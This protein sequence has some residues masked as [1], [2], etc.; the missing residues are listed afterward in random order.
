MENLHF[1]RRDPRCAGSG[2]CKQ[3]IE[4]PQTIRTE[5]ADVPHL[6][7]FS[8]YVIHKERRSIIF[9]AA[10]IPVYRDDSASVLSRRSVNFG[11][12]VTTLRLRLRR[13]APVLSFVRRGR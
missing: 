4:K 7:N 1:F 2:N 11:N 9:I 10:C 6:Q 3:P 5:C 8:M 12:T 13:W